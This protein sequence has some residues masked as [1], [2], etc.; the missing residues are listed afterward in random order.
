MSVQHYHRFWLENQKK[1]K[2]MRGLVTRS[3]KEREGV[4]RERNAQEGDTAVEVHV[5]LLAELLLALK[6]SHHLGLRARVLGNERSVLGVL[7]EL[8]KLLVEVERLIEVTIVTLVVLCTAVKIGEAVSKGRLVRE[9]KDKSAR[10]AQ[11]KVVD[12]L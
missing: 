4:G 12:V 9:M 11:A 1:K 7:A 10:R 5:D 2:D 6:S 8:A 3:E